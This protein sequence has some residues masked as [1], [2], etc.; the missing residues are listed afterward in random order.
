MAVTSPYGDCLKR[1]RLLN[2]K[3]G[4]RQEI[5]QVDDEVTVLAH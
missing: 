1:K 2:E 5:D 4:E 3:H